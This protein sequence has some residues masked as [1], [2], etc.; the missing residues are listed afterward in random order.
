VPTA[1]YRD[2]SSAT[3]GLAREVQRVLVRLRA[4]VAEEHPLKR[5]G[6]QG[7]QALGQ[8]L[9]KRVGDGSRI[10]E[11]RS[12][13]LRNRTHHVRVTVAGSRYRVPSVGVQPLVSILIDQP[14]AVPAHRADRELGVDREEGG[15]TA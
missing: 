9:A 1:E 7:R 12:S 5:V 10:E 8:T 2:D 6:A 3:G 4:R 14:R 11:Q 15:R 13:L